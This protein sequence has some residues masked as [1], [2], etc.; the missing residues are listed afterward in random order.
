MLTPLQKTAYVHAVTCMIS[1]FITLFFAVVEITLTDYVTTC[2][3]D[4]NVMML[5]IIGQT[6]SLIAP[7]SMLSLTAQMKRRLGRTPEEAVS[8][9]TM[10]I[11]VAMLAITL[12]TP[13]VVQ[14][15]YRS[16]VI[17][18][19]A[20]VW[21]IAYTTAIAASLLIYAGAICAF[22]LPTLIGEDE[23]G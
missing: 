5:V 6:T 7:V 17:A 18:M 4:A 21:I 20:W 14:A 22:V 2:P 3:I 9:V 15:C 23:K 1:S 12:N 8:T 10:L 13:P 19:E 11:V 16:T